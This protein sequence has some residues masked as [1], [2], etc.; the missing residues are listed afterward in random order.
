M[1]SM[2]VCDRTDWPV[3]HFAKRFGAR[4]D[5]VLGQIIV[6]IPLRVQQ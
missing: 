3:R 4:L 1:P 2:V 5:L 6:D